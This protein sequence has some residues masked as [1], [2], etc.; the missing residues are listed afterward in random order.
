MLVHQI[1]QNAGIERAT[2]GAHH[3]AVDRREAHGAGDASPVTDCAETRAIAE[4]RDDH[5][6]RREIRRERPQPSRD[7]RVREAMEAVAM[8]PVRR[9]LARQRECLRLPFLTAVERG[10]E[11]G[12]LRQLGSTRADGRDR[13]EIVGLVQRRERHER[14]EFLE[15]PIRYPLRHRVMG[16]TM[17][18]AVPDGEKIRAPQSVGRHPDED[19]RRRVVIDR[20]GLLTCQHNPVAAAYACARTRADAF[21]NPFRQKRGLRFGGIDGQLDAGRAGV[22]HRDASHHRC[23][24]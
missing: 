23:A 1:D 14:L 3:Q 22:D 17:N 12:D 19:M 18:D 2:A 9:D 6:A 21:E 24:S 20:A 13:R 4:V 16:P 11:A 8:H 5:A 7:E 10:V 15:K